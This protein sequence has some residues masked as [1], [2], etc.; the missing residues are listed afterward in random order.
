MSRKRLSSGNMVMAAPS[1]TPSVFTFMALRSFTTSNL[2]NLKTL[3]QMLL[4]PPR[5]DRESP[6]FELSVPHEKRPVAHP[7]KVRIM[8]DDHYGLAIFVPEREE[9]LMELLFGPGIEVS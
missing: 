4:R 6:L 3:I 7:G 9:Q 5:L 8:R 1:S 2:L